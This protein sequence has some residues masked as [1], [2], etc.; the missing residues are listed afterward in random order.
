M[1]L[2]DVDGKMLMFMMRSR[3]EAG[4]QPAPPPPPPPLPPPLLRPQI[5][6]GLLQRS[7]VCVCVGYRSGGTVTCGACPTIGPLPAPAGLACQDPEA[8][9]FST[10]RAQGVTAPSAGQ[11]RAVKMVYQQLSA[12]AQ[13]YGFPLLQ[14]RRRALARRCVPRHARGVSRGGLHQVLRQG[15]AWGLSRAPLMCLPAP[16]A[17]PR[18]PRSC[19]SS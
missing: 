7:T 15:R 11:P 3:A 9:C 16:A 13:Q 2:V 12:S 18:L 8:H 19:A 14:V 5:A 17:G 6:A 10:D 1:A 4:A